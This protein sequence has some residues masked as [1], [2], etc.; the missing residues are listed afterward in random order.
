VAVLPEALQAQGFA[1]L[2]RL[3]VSLRVGQR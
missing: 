3:R 2:E 1:F